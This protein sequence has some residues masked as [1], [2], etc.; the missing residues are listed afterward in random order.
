[1]ALIHV[2]QVECVTVED[3]AKLLEVSEH[4]VRRLIRCRKLRRVGDTRPVLIA[5]ASVATYAKDRGYWN[6]G[7]VKGGLPAAVRAGLRRAN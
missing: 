3:A 5:R 6:P 1:M 7:G 2:G 4:Q